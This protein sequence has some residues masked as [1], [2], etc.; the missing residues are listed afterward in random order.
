[1]YGNTVEVKEL[2][3]DVAVETENDTVYF[4]SPAV[5]RSISVGGPIAIVHHRFPARGNGFLE[6]VG[7]NKVATAGKPNDNHLELTV[8]EGDKITVEGRLKAAKVSKKGN[9]YRV[10]THVLLMGEAVPA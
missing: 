6:E 1:M 3:A 4:K 5:E 8:R 7:E 9:P 2:Y 10:L